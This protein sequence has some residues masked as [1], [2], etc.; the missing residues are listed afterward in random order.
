MKSKQL[1]NGETV[2]LGDTVHFNTKVRGV[3]AGVEFVVDDLEGG[4][5]AVPQKLDPMFGLQFEDEEI[6]SYLEDGD[7]TLK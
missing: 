4:V 7:L 1:P 3:D 5:L 2:T 6:S